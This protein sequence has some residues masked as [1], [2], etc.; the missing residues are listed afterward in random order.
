MRVA[1]LVAVSRLDV[2]AGNR[3]DELV[4]AHPD[5]TVEPPHREDD[6]EAPKG[7]IPRQRVLVVRVDERAVEVQQRRARHY[8]DAV[9]FSR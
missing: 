1:E 7:A 8:A 2:V 5:V 6:L 3:R 4:A 9:V